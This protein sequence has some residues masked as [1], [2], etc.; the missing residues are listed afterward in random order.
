MLLES[1]Q[2]AW[3]T[4]LN[5]R[6]CTSPL[7]CSGTAL[8]YPERIPNFGNP[9]EMSYLTT[10]PNRGWGYKKAQ[11]RAVLQVR[12]PPKVRFTLTAR[13]PLLENHHV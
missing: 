6:R 13:M 10:M 9:R 2:T 7:Q 5:L 11:Y 12:Q 4:A 1:D 8:I 3:A